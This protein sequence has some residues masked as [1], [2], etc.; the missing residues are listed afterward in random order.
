M[1]IKT[2]TNR[3][4]LAFSLTEVMVVSAIISSL[5]TSHFVR[6]KQLTLQTE[7]M[8]NLKQIGLAIQMYYQTEGAYPKAAFFPEKPKESPDSIINILA[9]G[10]GNIPA[11]MWLCPAAP[12]KMQE[13]GLT[14]VYNDTIGG[15]KSLKHP[16]KAWLMIELNCVS[17]STPKP[18]PRGYNILF[19]D[20][21]VITSEDLPPSITAKQQSMLYNL[22]NQ[23]STGL[24]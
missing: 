15:R 5:P 19:A 17:T 9:D 22:E 24:L 20:G 12:E 13:L 3:W 8:S 6:A 18:H 7:C 21:H 14:F 4:I 2:R 10:G 16:D 23:L 1:N 11:Q